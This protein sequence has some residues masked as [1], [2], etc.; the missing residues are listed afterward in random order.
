MCLFVYLFVYIYLFVCCLL[1]VDDY[2]REQAYHL[3]EQLDLQLTQMENTLNQVILNYNSKNSLTTSDIGTGG[4]G[5]S[6]GGNLAK[7]IDI[8]NEHHTVLG[9]LDMKSRSLQKEL[10][11]VSRELQQQQQSSS[12]TRGY[13]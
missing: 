12:G 4:S 7:I 11:T 13:D 10:L 1:Y 5:S 9:W 6:G 2:E 8:L 3:A